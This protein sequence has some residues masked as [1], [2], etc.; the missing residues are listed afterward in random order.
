MSHENLTQTL[1]N[2]NYTTTGYVKSTDTFYDA[3]WEAL[4]FRA[5]VAFTMDAPYEGR[6]TFKVEA[7]GD[8]VYLGDGYGETPEEAL[9]GLCKRRYM[10]TNVGTLLGLA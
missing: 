2:A 3:K 5:V 10:A 6:P 1:R 8:G 9:A 7:S 4:D